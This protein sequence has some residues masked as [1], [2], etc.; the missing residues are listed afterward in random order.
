MFGGPVEQSVPCS[1]SS[2][3][4]WPTLDQIL[5]KLALSVLKRWLHNLYI[6]V[7]KTV[8]RGDLAPTSNCSD[9]LSE[10]L[11][12]FFAI[13]TEVRSNCHESIYTRARAIEVDP[14][15]QMFR[16]LAWIRIEVKCRRKGP[17]L[18]V[19]MKKSVI[20]K[21]IISVRDQNRK[22]YT[23]PQLT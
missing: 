8:R 1:F 7:L 16:T 4:F 13:Q 22:C 18:T 20:T 17:G 12:C 14:S 11:K 19:L 6:T 2:C 21:V 23:T 10:S 15:T 9:N 5:G 3:A